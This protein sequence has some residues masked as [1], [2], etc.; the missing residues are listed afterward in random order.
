M[1]AP[2]PPPASAVGKPSGSATT[3]TASRSATAG[4]ARPPRVPTA[5]APQPPESSAT[6]AADDKVSKCS[7][8]D[9]EHIREQFH[10][11]ATITTRAMSA[12]KRSTRPRP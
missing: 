7:E 9:V 11:P 5:D 6:L 10:L 8:V 3:A 12:E 2:D 1:A 4:D